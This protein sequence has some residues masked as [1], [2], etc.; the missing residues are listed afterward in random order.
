MNAAVAPEVTARRSWS[1][2]LI[3]RCSVPPPKFGTREWLSLAEGDH[4]KIAAVV[5]AAEAWARGGDELP[6]LLA[7]EVADARRAFK[8]TEDAEYR[9]RAAEHRE[10][11]K[12][13]PKAGTFVDRRAAQLAAAAPQPGDY[14]GKGAGA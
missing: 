7:Q 1:Y 3:S 6:E 9:A 10:H 8:E 2:R 12:R 14:Q 5:I 11:Y 4:R 13:L